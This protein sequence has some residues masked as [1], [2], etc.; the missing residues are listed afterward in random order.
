[1]CVRSPTQSPTQQE[2]RNPSH[3]CTVAH[4]NEEVCGFAGQS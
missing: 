2:C 4:K 1:V 3:Y